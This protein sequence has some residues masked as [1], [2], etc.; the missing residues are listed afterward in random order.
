M[1]LM[2]LSAGVGLAFVAATAALAD[3][4][5]GRSAL[6]TKPVN[7]SARAT[8]AQMASAYPKAGKGVGFANLGCILGTG[9]VLKDCRV[10]GEA[11]QGFGFGDAA[12]G[13]AGSFKAHYVAGEEGA[14]ILLPLEFDP[15][16]T[17]KGA[18]K[19]PIDPINCLPPLCTLEIVPGKPTPAQP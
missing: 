8:P 19:P 4:A 11:P 12:L 17:V 3:D 9:G 1:G 15:P 16:E 2:R 6:L 13:L 7:W 5:P 14:S 10:V 18:A